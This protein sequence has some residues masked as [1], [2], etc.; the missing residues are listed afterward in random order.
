MRTARWIP[1]A[2]NT[3]SEYV[4]LIAF[5]LQQWFSER[6]SML[7]YT[8]IAYLGLFSQTSTQVSG[9]QP[10]SYSVHTA[11][12]PPMVKRSAP[13]HSPPSTHQMGTSRLLQILVVA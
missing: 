3:L 4:I 5:P 1:K 13:N 2:T 6:V 12:F 9:A 10:A 7:R 8:Y 11:G